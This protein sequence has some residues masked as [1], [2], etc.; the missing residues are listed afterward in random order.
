MSTR[1][2]RDGRIAG[3]LGRAKVRPCGQG[4]EKAEGQSIWAHH[5]K[6]LSLAGRFFM[7]SLLVVQTDETA[8]GSVWPV[9]GVD[10]AWLF[11]VLSAN[12]RSQMVINETGGLQI[13][14]ADCGA[15]EFE[16][17]FFHI[18]TDGIRQRRGDGNFV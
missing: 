15:E 3:L 2:R 7:V 5:K 10:V 11:L 17:S 4:V 18:P 13:R 16:S 8:D 6:K 12:A 14:I 9:F 1:T